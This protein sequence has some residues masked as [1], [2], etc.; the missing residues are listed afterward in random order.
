MAVKGEVPRSERRSRRWWNP[1][2]KGN[3]RSSDPTLSQVRTSDGSKLKGQKR[4]RSVPR[5]NGEKK[6]C[7]EECP[8]QRLKLIC[9]EKSNH[10]WSSRG[11]MR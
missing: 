3:K 1:S 8:N 11:K 4:R 7:S 5:S 6:C 9:G 2:T 10:L